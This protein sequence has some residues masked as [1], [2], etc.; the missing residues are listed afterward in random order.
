MVGY[1]Q[2]FA[3]FYTL[4]SFFHHWIGYNQSDVNAGWHGSENDNISFGWEKQA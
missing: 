4:G 2:Y 3:N 1:N